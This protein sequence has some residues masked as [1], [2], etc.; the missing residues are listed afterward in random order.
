MGDPV[1][2]VVRFPAEAI[3]T[4]VVRPEPGQTLDEV[5]HNLTYFG[6]DESAEEI[7]RIDE[8][9]GSDGQ[10]SHVELLSPVTV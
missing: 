8:L 7:H 4:Y 1:K 10:I 6:Y 9:T 2:V 5:M 3:I